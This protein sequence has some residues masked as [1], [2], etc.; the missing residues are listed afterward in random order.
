MSKR[1]HDG[2]Y[3]GMGS[4]RMQE[5]E[6]GSM[7]R[8]DH[9]AMANLPQNVMIKPWA[10]HEAYLPEGLDDTIHGIDKQINTLDNGKRDAHLEPKK[11]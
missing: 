6:D 5:A 2:N 3:A 4:R 11:V 8:E 7:I 9:S 10:D 1:Y